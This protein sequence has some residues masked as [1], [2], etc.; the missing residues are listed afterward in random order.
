MCVRELI[1]QLG[2][3]HTFICI[4]AKR[5]FDATYGQLMEVMHDAWDYN[6]TENQLTD[7]VEACKRTA[8]GLVNGDK[9]RLV[10]LSSR[11]QV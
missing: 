3:K 11:Q 4:L 5:A 8:A 7:K 10:D 6:L 1:F 2:F 9:R